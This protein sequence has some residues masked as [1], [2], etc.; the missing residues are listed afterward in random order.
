M[1]TNTETEQPMT[2]TVSAPADLLDLVGQ[3]LG[4]VFRLTYPV[5]GADRP[6]CIADA[7]VLYL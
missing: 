7:V 2:T 5:D 6:A 4:A 3:T 1:S